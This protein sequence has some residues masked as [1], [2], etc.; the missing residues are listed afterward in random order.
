[1]MTVSNLAR[2]LQGSFSLQAAMGRT[3]PRKVISPV[4]ATPFRT[5][6][7][8]KSEIMAAAI[9]IPAKGHL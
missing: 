5:G 3:F 7:P 2:R 6:L 4:I 8:V 9:V 1:M